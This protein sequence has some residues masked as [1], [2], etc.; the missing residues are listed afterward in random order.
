MAISFQS[1]PGKSTAQ[2]QAAYGHHIRSVAIDLKFCQRHAEPWWPA[3]G[4]L[5]CLTRHGLELFRI[6]A[7]DQKTTFETLINTNGSIGTAYS[8]MPTFEFNTGGFAIHRVPIPCWAWN[9][10]E[11]R[12]ELAEPGTPDHTQYLLSF[13]GED[14]SDLGR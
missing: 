12:L 6:V 8:S 1:P 13:K 11:W 9:T 5:Y 10:I 7:V 3:E 14:R 2:I 4:D